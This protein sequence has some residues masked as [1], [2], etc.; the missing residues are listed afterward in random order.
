M[1]EKSHTVAQ[2]Y[3]KLFLEPT[4]DGTTPKPRLW[5]Y[6]KDKPPFQRSISSNTVE[7]GAYEYLDSDGNLDVSTERD[8]GKFRENTSA[9]IF[10]LMMQEQ[11]LTQPQKDELTRY[12]ISQDRRTVKHRELQ[13][14]VIESVI[15]NLFENKEEI[16]K[17]RE[18]IRA[19]HP[20]ISEG[21]LEQR[22]QIVMAVLKPTF[23]VDEKQPKLFSI[24]ALGMNSAAEG[25]I[26]GLHWN[27]VKAP[28][29]TPFVFSDA[30]V[31]IDGPLQS[32]GR[33][34]LPLSRS[35]LLEVSHSNNS[36]APYALINS[37]QVNE[38]NRLI[39]RNAHKEVY[40]GKN[41]PEIQKL[42]NEN[43]S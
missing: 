6:T 43:L 39:I 37:E 22:L 34:V 16:E 11:V 32:S 7:L 27:I 26:S 29:D 14:P 8:L 2:F 19:R 25:V 41:S 9:P 21:E 13:K 10:H 40:S 20:G 5:I 23:R 36:R 24:L 38:W 35:L 4:T 3:Q 31:C 28:T 30:P 1:P 42:V 33:L 18:F 17:T 12:I 15:K